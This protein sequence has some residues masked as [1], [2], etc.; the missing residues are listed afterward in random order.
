M[1]PSHA[2][3]P[4]HATRNTQQTLRANTLLIRTPEGIVFS[5]LLAGPMSRFLAWLIDLFCVLALTM[6]LG[7][8]LAVLQVISVG[9]AQAVGL[10]LQFVVM[11]GYAICCEWRWRGQTLGKRILRL[12]VVDAQGLRLKFSQVVI[13]NLLRFVDML[14]FF[15]L[16]GGVAC[17]VSRRAQRL[18]DLAANTLVVRIP[19][20][21]EPNLDQLAAGKFNSLRNYPHLEARLRQRVSA[22]EAALAL[23]AL[24]R[25]DLLDPPARVE[26][27]AQI[28]EH[29]HGKVQF[30]SE[31]TDGVADEQF[32]R[33]VVD[34][35]YRPRRKETLVSPAPQE[36]LPVAP[37]PS[38]AARR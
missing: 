5:Q 32:V 37:Q 34:S 33:N 7:T 30:P 23:Q 25:R 11:I 27:F 6:L 26:L 16:V 12:R 14:P 18:G 4:G 15:Y 9:I 1:K 28:A 24:V 20:I 31:A 8:L 19:K 29:F 22:Q 38:P 35:L 17:A 10:L 36:S 13:R 3:N 2:P 21:A